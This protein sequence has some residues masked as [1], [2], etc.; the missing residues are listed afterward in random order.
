M[1]CEVSSSIVLAWR[2]EFAGSRFAFI[3]ARGSS[4]K[5]WAPMSEIVSGSTSTPG[6]P[7]ACYTFG[8]QHAA[9]WRFKCSSHTCPGLTPLAGYVGQPGPVDIR[10]CQ[11]H[12]DGHCPACQQR[13]EGMDLQV[14]C[15]EICTL[16]TLGGED[17]TLPEDEDDFAAD[18]NSNA[19]SEVADEALRSFHSEKFL[20]EEEHMVS[21]CWRWQ[22]WVR[23][24]LHQARL[25]KTTRSLVETLSMASYL[26]R[27]IQWIEQACE[28]GAI[29]S[30]VQM[31]EHPLVMQVYTQQNISFLTIP[32]TL[33]FGV[34][35]QSVSRHAPSAAQALDA[36]L[37]Q[38]I[39]HVI[40]PAAARGKAA[41]IRAELYDVLVRQAILAFY[42]A[43]IRAQST[44]RMDSTKIRPFE[45]NRSTAKLFFPVPF[46][47]ETGGA[48]GSNGEELVDLLAFSGMRLDERDPFLEN[49]QM[50]PALLLQQSSHQSED[51]MV[52]ALYEVMER[53]EFLERSL[54][55]MHWMF[56]QCRSCIENRL[57]GH[58]ECRF[59]AR[60]LQM[61]VLKKWAAFVKHCL[62]LKQLMKAENK[63]R[64]LAKTS[65]RKNIV[66]PAICLLLALMFHDESGLLQETYWE[67]RRA[68]FGHACSILTRDVLN[69]E[70]KFT[71]SGSY[72]S[73]E[74]WSNSISNYCWKRKQHRTR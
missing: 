72:S 66:H 7:Y 19:F 38:V 10:L 68:L 59:D 54:R 47:G 34:I 32:A 12:R 22:A 40:M 64:A 55:E 50:D 14:Q 1:L 71:S 36:N 17:Q 11:Q 5:A 48:S 6:E 21:K 9:K 4:G 70:F 49:H 8:C 46:G 13:I 63:L 73:Y 25:L 45:M 26:S 69:M 42:T 53:T 16:T 37:P 41:G 51:A 15:G 2:C 23:R 52:R 61:T 62:F 30:I 27:N 57:T 24:R 65:R 3:S 33:C 18:E 58:F 31:L 28:D 29:A 44:A 39:R 20:V 43:S 56:A 74:E 35:E 60:C 67:E